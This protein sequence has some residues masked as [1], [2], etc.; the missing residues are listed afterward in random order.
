MMAK[1]VI[2]SDEWYPV[3]EIEINFEGKPVPPRCYDTTIELTDTEFADYLRV[4]AEFRKWQIKL[5]GEEK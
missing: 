5:G 2:E 1:Y 4:R 3:Y